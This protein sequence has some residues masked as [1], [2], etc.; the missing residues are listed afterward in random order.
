MH[1][2]P[3]PGLGSTQV[4]VVSREYLGPLEAEAGLG[5]PMHLP[6]CL[7]VQGLGS[8]VRRSRVEIPA[9]AG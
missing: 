1:P 2:P 8:R 9:P 4:C 7:L 3:N 5:Q 6:G